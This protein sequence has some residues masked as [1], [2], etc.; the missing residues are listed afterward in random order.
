MR[1]HIF[2]KR[3]KRTEHGQFRFARLRH[4]FTRLLADPGTDLRLFPFIKKRLPILLL[5]KM[6]RVL[7]HRKILALVRKKDNAIVLSGCL[8]FGRVEKILVIVLSML[9]RSRIV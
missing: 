9:T 1:Y 5:C 8:D 7:A 4:Q 2:P 3:S 6:A